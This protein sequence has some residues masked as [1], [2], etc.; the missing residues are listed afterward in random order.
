MKVNESPIGGEDN[1]YEY[2][3]RCRMADSIGD[4]LSDE[5]V[6]ARQCYEEILSEVDEIIE[7]HRT[8]LSKAQRFKELMLGNRE[9][10]FFDDK[11][12]A[13]KWKYDRI[14][15]NE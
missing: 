14:L 5:K 7:Y 2:H 9:I 3:R 1:T 11:E 10:D 13:T 8:Y 12:L 6:D 4:Y 15:L